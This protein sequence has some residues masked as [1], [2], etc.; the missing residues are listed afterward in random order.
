[1]HKRE[2]SEA[3]ADK[4]VSEWGNKGSW[5]DKGREWE[6][7]NEREPY[8]ISTYLSLICS[9][10]HNNVRHTINERKR[11]SKFKAECFHFKYK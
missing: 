6:W 2:E 1:M 8:S 7:D 5:D 11:S 10:N 4:R 3:T 9:Y